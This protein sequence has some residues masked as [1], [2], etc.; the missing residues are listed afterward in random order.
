MDWFRRSITNAW[1]LLVFLLFACGEQVRPTATP[2]PTLAPTET[3]APT[4]TVIPAGL[5]V[6]VSA[7]THPISPLVYGTN[8]GP[9]LVVTVDVQ[10][11][12]EASGLTYLR[13]PG[14]RFG[15]T[16]N[17]QTFDID[18][19]I[20]LA[21]IIDAEITISVRLLGGTPERA[22][23]LVRYT[24]IEK[25]YGVKYW[26]IGNEPSIYIDFQDA[27]EWDTEYYNEQW[28]IYAEAM[29]AVDPTIELLGPNIHQISAEHAARPKDPSGR[30]WLDEFLIANG[31]LVDVVT[32]HRYPF[33]IKRTEPVPTF[34]QLRN[35]PQ[36]WDEIIP[37]LRETVREL[38]GED[39]PVGIMEINSNYT[40]VSSLETSPDSLYNAI[41]WGDVLGR[42]IQQQ[43]EQVT[44]FALQN[45]RSGWGML[46]RTEPRPTY[47]TYQL[48]QRFGE[49]L[50]FSESDDPYVSVLAARRSDGA[51]TVMLINLNDD[52][53]EKPLHIVGLETNEA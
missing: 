35:N 45:N 26:S 19:L 24:N 3:P 27:L 13:F 12:F 18:R 41:W 2:E 51:L 50:L 48:Y 21:A 47:F 53:V 28:R 49:E 23:E 30:D 20:D 32:V 37:A 9:W 36:E 40:D 4:P 1:L 6:D 14:G 33:P 22:A 38:T 10:D 25:G 11:E 31:D 17:V 42:M 34:D 44:H 43:V 39:K 15:D 8:Y 5:Y 16:R 29:L 52:A 46:G 7:E